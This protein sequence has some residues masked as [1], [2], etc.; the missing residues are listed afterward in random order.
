MR[1]IFLGAPGA[2]KGTQANLISAKFS[3]PKLSTGDMLRAEIANRSILGKKVEGIMNSGSLVSDELITEIVKKRLSQDDCFKGFVLDGFPRTIQQADN[4]EKILDILPTKAKTYVFNI[5]IPESELIDR[6][7]G[8]FTCSNC[9]TAYHS[10]YNK[11]KVEGVCDK[12]GSKEFLF[13]ED[14]KE[15]AVKVRLQIYKEKTAPL[16]DYYKRKSVL[17]NINGLGTIEEINSEISDVVSGNAAKHKE[18][19]G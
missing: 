12:C 18:A 13:R 3:I 11:P 17:T 7:S 10:K 16:I 15:E 8:R 5:D 1:I 14:D 2:G 19:R 6:F 4:L 9:N